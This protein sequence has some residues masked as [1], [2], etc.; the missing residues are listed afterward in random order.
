MSQWVAPFAKLIYRHPA[1]DGV[2]TSLPLR[3]IWRPDDSWGR[4]GCDYIAPL[5]AIAP[6]ANLY[7]QPMAA[8]GWVN[9]GA[10]T[11]Y[12][13]TTV[14]GGGTAT[15]WLHFYDGAAYPATTP[16]QGYCGIFQHDDL[17]QNWILRYIR[18][19][20]PQGQQVTTAI[21]MMVQATARVTLEDD[22][23]VLD[24]GG[25]WE[26]ATL[27]LRL[28]VASQTTPGP[29]LALRLGT[30]TDPLSPEQMLSAVTL[31][32]PAQGLEQRAVI[33]EYIEDDDRFPGGHV[34]IR[35]GGVKD[36]WHFYH[37]CIRVTGGEALMVVGGSRHLVNVTPLSYSPPSEQTQGLWDSYVPPFC[38]GGEVKGLP[39]ERWEETAEIAPEATGANGWQVSG[40][41]ASLDEGQ[42]CPL[43]A[44]TPPATALTRPVL[45][46][47][48][49][50]H[51]A[52][53]EVPEGLPAP[54]DT[55]GTLTLESLS[56]TLNDRWQGST[57]V[58]TFTADDEELFDTWRPGGIVD[59]TLGW[60]GW[61]AD[62]P[63]GDDEPP[64][65]PTAT[66][67]LEGYRVA[68]GGLRRY[69][70]ADYGGRPRL[71]VQLEDYPA[72][73]LARTAVI[74]M[75]QAGQQS[76]SQW[77]IS[78][79]NHIGLDEARIAIDPALPD[80]TPRGNPPSLPTLEP[81]DGESWAEHLTRVCDALN[82]VWG[83]R[84]G[85]LFFEPRPAPYDPGTD[86]I[87]LTIDDES[88]EAEDIIFD[89]DMSRGAASYRNALKVTPRDATVRPAYRV[90]SPETVT[91]DGGLYW[92]HRGD[93][94]G[95]PIAELD[96]LGHNRY[97]LYGRL[98]WSGP[99]KPTLKPGQFVKVNIE[100]IGVAPGAIF[101]V[102]AVTHN[103][104]P[105]AMDAT[106]TVDAILDSTPA[107]EEE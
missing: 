50:W 95:D 73:V 93:I 63:E 46:L 8:A 31:P 79:C 97:N 52:E 12:N 99:A 4:H 74:D 102:T 61:C 48:W 35:F 92:A 20:P 54:E 84:D 34:L 67:T 55:D 11:S 103:I 29:W 51:D 40:D 96:A 66:T 69:R 90:V 45:W 98:R 105:A 10:N 75:W 65:A 76:V 38:L 62:V 53:V 81:Q 80:F 47:A 64:E 72:A 44:F 42:Y 41:N 36:W 26:D 83:W 104:D 21:A 3:R 49:E 25:E 18:Y 14:P 91:E 39:G 94:A 33:W 106:M 100:G 2:Q 60:Q 86:T 82:A 27:V 15:S 78:V 7:P 43:V 16:W 89:A 24:P 1:S 56:V 58:A 71:E 87:T 28:P 88:D 37:Q 9:A 17:P 22:A 5:G 23:F 30:P 85:K 6:S 68:Q 57:A 107:E 70:T 19:Q 101:R 13:F 59:M 32:E 77:L